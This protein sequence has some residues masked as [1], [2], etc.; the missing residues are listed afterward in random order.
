MSARERPRGVS[1]ARRLVQ[2]A[3]LAAFVALA[4]AAAYPPLSFPASNVMLRLDPIAAVYSL[5]SVHSLGVAAAFWPAW[6]LIGLTALGSRFFC[7]WVCPLGTCLDAAGAV[8]PR[9]LKYYEPT[10]SQVR[11][12]RKGADPAPGTAK[13]T[14]PRGRAWLRPKYLL[15]ALVLVFALARVN[16]LYFAS[17]MVIVNGT[18]HYALMPIVPIVFIALIL[19]AIFYRPRFWCESL[20]PSGALLGLVSWAGKKFPSRAGVLAVAKQPS[21]CTSCGVCY[22][23]CSFGVEEP[24]T[25]EMPGRLRSLDC[26]SCGQCVGACPEGALSLD[27]FGR[28]L[29]VAGAVGARSATDKPSSLPGS[30]APPAG[31]FAVSR[32]EFLGSV[33]LGAVLLAG[34]GIGMGDHKAPVLRMP[35]AQDESL[36]LAR[37]NRC[38]ECARACPPGSLKPMGIESGLQK[39]WTPRFVPREAGCIFDQCSQACQ[40]VCPAGAILKVDPK[41]TKIGLAALN[42]RTCLGWRGKYCLVCQ[43]RCRFD[44]IAAKG[45]RPSVL[46]DKC[47]GCGSCEETCPTNPPSIV[48]RPLV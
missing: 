39:L 30:P 16:L 17:P 34:Y 32:R 38:Q 8:K 35:G 6:V 42:R 1:V 11:Q 21:A 43:E 36:F 15:L 5:I 10:G 18:V 25:S 41:D 3:F 9:A 14:P 19:A 12:L 22:K 48:V 28:T 44:A 40:R 31:R 13:H 4:V 2:A 20:C 23:A 33:G 47:T 26:T 24:F 7:G 46:E 45:L 27:G 29:Y 37:C